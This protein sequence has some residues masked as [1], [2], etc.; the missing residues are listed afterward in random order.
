MFT[1][2]KIDSALDAEITSA[3]AELEKSRDNPEKYNATLDRIGR[4]Q[5][6]KPQSG[7]FKLRERDQGAQRVQVSYSPEVNQPPIGAKR[8]DRVK[9]MVSLFCLKK[10]RGGIFGKTKR[11]NVNFESRVYF[12]AYS[13]R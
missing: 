10:S 7:L 9:N 5:K 8:G 13:E 2:R 3:L 1:Q 12:L 6:T 11:I 4:L